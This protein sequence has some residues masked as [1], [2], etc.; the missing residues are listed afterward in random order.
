[1]ITESRAFSQCF[2]FMQ[3]DLAFHLFL[4]QLSLVLVLLYHHHFVLKVNGIVTESKNTQPMGKESLLLPG[5][6]RRISHNLEK[7]NYHVAERK[8]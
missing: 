8:F 3:L 5:S 1:M 7:L 6:K 4:I 2:Y